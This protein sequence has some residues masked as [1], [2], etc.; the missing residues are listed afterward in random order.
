MLDVNDINARSGLQLV[1][2]LTRQLAV[3][4]IGR[5]IEHDVAVVSNIRVAFS[6]QLLGNLNNFRNVMSRSR[7]HIRAQDIQRVEVFM[8]LGNH[9]VYQRNKALAVFI[10]TLD[11]FVVNVGDV[12]HIL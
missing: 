11:D 8:H 6:D 10:G 2:I 1:E 7:L 3:V 12:A 9:A 4:R 5:H